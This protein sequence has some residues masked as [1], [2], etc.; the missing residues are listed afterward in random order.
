MGRCAAQ[1]SAAPTSLY[2][3][4]IAMERG[5]PPAW[6]GGWAARGAGRGV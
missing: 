5:S 6:P 4:G 2:P 1:I 3:H